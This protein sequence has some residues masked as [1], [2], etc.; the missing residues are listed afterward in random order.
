MNEVL[1]G[2]DVGTTGCKSVAYTLD[3]TEV[4][5]SYREYRLHH[6]NPLWVEEDPEEWWDAVVQTTRSVVESAR[7]KQYE[8][9]AAGVSCTNALVCVDASGNPLLPA[10]M[11]LDQRSE[12]QARWIREHI[13]AE[14]VFAITGN[15][16][17]AGSYSAPI[18]RWIQDNLPEVYSRVHKFLV[19]TGF[20]VQ[21]LTGEFTMDFSRACTTML[22][23]I[24]QRAWSTALCDDFAIDT[25]KLPPLF[26][27]ST[28]VGRITEQAAKLTGL[29]PGVPVVAGSVDTVSAAI[30]AGAIH[31]AQTCG[32]L[33]TVARF[34]IVTGGSRFDDRMLNF[35]HGTPQGWLTAAAINA[36]GASLRWFRDT[37]FQMEAAAAVEQGISPFDLMTREA[38]TAAPGA[39]GL[40]YLPYLAG[41]RSPLWN[42]NA[43][44]VIY[45]LTLSH[46][47]ADIIRCFLEGIGYA[48][49]HNLEI[50]EREYGVSFDGITLAGG[51]AKSRLWRQII[52]D[53]LKAEVRI[54]ETLETEALGSALLAGA[55]CGAYS[56]LE[57]AVQRAVRIVDS[58]SYDAQRARRYDRMFAGYLACVD[59]F[60]SKFDELCCTIQG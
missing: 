46:N 5:K 4:A 30:G 37:L 18:I 47:R 17:A 39:G 12:P 21:R 59:H 54:P 14:R 11:Q 60:S 2:V 56:N 13:G 50:M 55:G 23:D 48:V 28:V 36:A 35:C 52:A 53:I 45:G 24:R 43:R 16:I 20:V 22:F 15:R 44:A 6:P 40:L 42:G 57:L 7:A 1:L 9:I 41:E 10:I 8:V 34:C 49:R 25:G 38:E 33:G 19:P 29:K 31:Q 3:G 27:S 58:V 26:S 32:V 51:G